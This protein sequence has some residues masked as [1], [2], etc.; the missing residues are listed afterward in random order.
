MVRFRH[1]V[2]CTLFL[3]C[4]FGFAL[5]QDKPSDA[6]E[7]RIDSLIKQMTIQEKAGPISQYD[8][9]SPQTMELV[10][11]GEVGSLFNVLGA[12]KTNAA[13]KIAMEQSR[14]KIPVLFGFD[15]IHGY[16]T[17]FPVPIGSASSFDP[18][19]IEQSEL[20]PDHVFHC[21]DWESR[22]VTL[23]ICRIDAA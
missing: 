1:G 10:K 11:K 7:K 17:V 13:Q 6:I 4:A 19:M 5:A 3:L 15:V 2:G 20:S 23:T 16:R 8:G 9:V 12:E 18:Q 21:Q 14:L 22:R